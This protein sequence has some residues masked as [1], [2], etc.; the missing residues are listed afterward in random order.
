MTLQRRL[1]LGASLMVLPV[2][3]VGAEA[4]RTNTLERRALETLGTGLGRN[5]T[6]AELE[7]AMFDQVEA[8]WRALTGLDPDARKEFRLSGQVVDYRLE[9][10]RSELSPD[11]QPLADQVAAVQRDIVATG[12]SIFQLADAGQHDLAFKVALS[13]LKGRLQPALTV[14]NRQIYRQARENSVSQA[15]AR[16]KEIVLGERVVLVAIVLGALSVGLLS[17]WLLARSLTRPITALGR[18]M[19]GKPKAYIHFCFTC[20][21]GC[22]SGPLKFQGWNDYGE[23]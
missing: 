21:S 19:A 2:L 11:E 9:R 23:C 6:Y 13:E 12:D 14:L 22:G 15:F 7:T 8:V 5:R 3:L 10:W 18:A 20:A 1:L 17:A 16:V 4:F